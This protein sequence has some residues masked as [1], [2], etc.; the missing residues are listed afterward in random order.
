MLKKLK[1]IL[2]IVASF[3]ASLAI[4]TFVLYKIFVTPQVKVALTLLNAKEDITNSLDF[5]RSNEEK[6]IV[7]IALNQAGE[8]KYAFTA[9]KSPI[10][11][12]TSAE[13]TTVGNA[14]SS[15]SK[16]AFNSLVSLDIYADKS[17]ILINFPLFSG[18]IKIPFEDSNSV[19]STTNNEKSAS[20]PSLFA[21]LLATD[22][23]FTHFFNTKK[24]EL[25]SLLRQTEIKITEKDTVK[26]GDTEK[27]ADVYEIKL[28]ETDM[29]TFSE[30]LKSYSEQKNTPL[31]NDID[32]TLIDF[33][34]NNTIYLKIKNYNLYEINIVNRNGENHTVTFSAASNQFDTITYFKNGKTE[35][36]RK[37]TY[38]KDETTDILTKNG[39]KLF[40]LVRSDEQSSLYLDN[41]K[42]KITII[43]TG[44]NIA[45]DTLSYEN[46]EL[47][48]GDVFS[49]N[50]EYSLKKRTSTETVDFNKAGKYLD[51][52]KLSAEDLTDVLSKIADLVKEIPFF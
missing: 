30:I 48:I 39:K 45:E 20:S 1:S 22:T 47:S 40:S 46:L 24:N 15:V 14:D 21:Y 28:T 2:I 25:I 44:M 37:R 31:K 16:L 27:K 5:Y 38:D 7:N 13:L 9:V 50:G 18:G 52:S 34:K 51:V 41:D 17:N 8:S 12:N 36:T 4:I 3:I 42:T 49:A 35:F 29:N 10:L 32:K 11:E 26:I 19:S 33:A 23:D 6:D 43:A